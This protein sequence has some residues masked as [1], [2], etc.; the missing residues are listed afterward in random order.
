MRLVL[1]GSGAAGVD[2]VAQDNAPTR[3]ESAMKRQ[4][5]SVKKAAAARRNGQLGGRPAKATPDHSTRKVLMVAGVELRA[6]FVEIGNIRTRLL[7]L[8]AEGRR[9]ELCL[10][11]QAQAMA[12]AGA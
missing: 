9:I 1:R 5:A 8:E 2:V 3:K 7:Q 10:R 4:Y 12:I 11:E 6:L